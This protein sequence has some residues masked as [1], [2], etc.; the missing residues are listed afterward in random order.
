MRYFCL[1]VLILCISFIHA[2]V[3]SKFRDNGLLILKGDAN[4]DKLQNPED[5]EKAEDQKPAPDKAKV[6]QKVRTPE[7]GINPGRDLSNSNAPTVIDRR[8]GKEY[9]NMNPLLNELRRV[10]EAKRRSSNTNPDTDSDDYSSDEYMKY[11]QDDFKNHWMEKKFEALNSTVQ[12]G[13]V[14]NMAS[15]R[16]W[17]VPCGD[18]NQHDVPWGSCMMDEECDPEYRI[19]RGDYFCGRTSFVCCSLQYTTFDLY[20]GLDPSFESSLST[21]S[22]EKTTTMSSYK[23]RMREKKKRRNERNKRKRKIKESIIRIV[24]EIKKTLHKA[25]QNATATRK[26]KTRELRKLIKYI[27]KQYIKDRQSVAHVHEL[28]IAKVDERLQKNLNQIKG[29][30][31]KFLANETFREILVNGTA[32]GHLKEFLRTHPKLRKIITQRR[33]DGGLLE[34]VPDDKSSADVEYDMEYGVLYY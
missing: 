26:K 13:D 34:P 24:K 4:N 1:T 11:W 19:F 23:K 10:F 17:G 2:S 25:Y 3:Y 27:K 18:P 30:N 31:E 15:A 14:V 29:F 8:F 20:Q 5:I 33:Q 22:S 16:P 12:R 6:L 9:H 28:D 7:M 32:K 21:D